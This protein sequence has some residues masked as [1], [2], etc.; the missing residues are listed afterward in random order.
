MASPKFE[1]LISDEG[2]AL[3]FVTPPIHE[4]SEMEDLKLLQFSLRECTSQGNREVLT[5]ELSQLVAK[6]KLIS[7]SRLANRIASVHEALGD[8]AAAKLELS[9]VEAVD[10]AFHSSWER[11]RAEMEFA[12][13]NPS[14][15]LDQLKILVDRGDS[16][17][18]VRLAIAAIQTKDLDLAMT[19]SSKALELRPEGYAECLLR[20]S[21]EL[22]GGNYAAAIV[23]LKVAIEDRPN[24][25]HAHTNLA[26]AYVGLGRYDRAFSTLKKAVSLDPFNDNAIVLLADIAAHL[27]R[28]NEIVDTFLL[29]VEFEQKSAVVWQ[30]FARSLVNSRR[31]SECIEALRNQGAL[32]P[33]LEVWNNLGVAYLAKKEYGESIRC[34]RQ[35]LSMIDL[36]SGDT[37]ES[38]LLIARNLA[39]VLYVS[40]AYEVLVSFWTKWCQSHDVVAF[41]NNSR[42]VEFYVFVYDALVKTENFL[43]ARRLADGI[44]S[45]P[46]SSPELVASLVSMIIA[47]HALHRD[48]DTRLWSLVDRY[49]AFRSGAPSGKDVRVA[50][51]FAFA[52]IEM[53]RLDE[54][55]SLIDSVKSYLYR[56][57]YLTATFGL[58]NLRKGRHEKGENL[59][60]MA[61]ELARTTVDR[62][63]IRQKMYLELGRREGEA[64]TRSRAN[65]K[66]AMREVQ[67]ETV[68]REEATDLLAR[69][70]KRSRHRSWKL[71]RQ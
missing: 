37:S 54:A 1:I 67:G 45:D 16:L 65:L 4:I 56:D 30:R 2:G 58:L 44:F 64:E 12:D 43:K 29:F 6:Q 15:A 55:S 24:S 27:G 18:A 35:G 36:S 53:G 21:L 57:A 63:R 33:S 62:A 39:H 40:G 49:Y 60:R 23:Y 38:D 66:R 41:R 69:L 26:F 70:E 8:R 50:N 7:S 52:L 5:K 31:Y 3:S 14:A 10:G 22:V 42:L 9:D 25:S 20:A 46:D 68:L 59:Y 19:W 17:S 13:G 48:D 47:R 61:I 28:D 32:R 11:R 71:K 34:F 51:N